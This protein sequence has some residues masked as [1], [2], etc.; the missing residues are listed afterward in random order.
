MDF[1]NNVNEYVLGLIYDGFDL[2]YICYGVPGEYEN[3][4]K[5]LGECQ[6]LPLNPASP[7]DGYWVIYQDAATGDRVDAI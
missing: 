7:S 3:A 6:W 2:K 4:P 1:E 5:H